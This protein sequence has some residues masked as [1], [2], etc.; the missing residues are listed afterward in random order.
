MPISL[1]RSIGL[2]FIA[3][4]AFYLSGYLV[5]M[6]A[7]RIL[8]PADY[9]K[10]SLVITLTL[11]IA[12]LIGSSI[13]IAM[14]KFLSENAQE[15]PG[16]IPIIK[17][18]G[19]V[20]QALCMGL[21]TIGFYVS[22]PAIAGLLG[23][24][25]LAPLLAISAFIIPLYA[26]DSFYFYYYSGTQRFA[27]QSFLKL[28]RSLLRI[29]VIL[30]LGYFLK[31]Q[32]I[33]AG[34]LLV[35]LAVFLIALAIDKKTATRRKEMLSVE[36]LAFPLR[37]FLALALPM[38][39]FLFLFET[40]LSFDIYLIKYLFEDNAQA[41]LYNAA[42]TVAR[43]P[44]YLFYALTLLLL[45][46][47]AASRA[48]GDREKTRALVARALRF[49]LVFAFP[50]FA[51]AF[52]YPHTITHLLFGEGFSAAAAFLPLLALALGFLSI[53]YVL[54]FAYHGAGLIRIPIMFM[55]GG[56]GLNMLFD[57]LFLSRYGIDAL[58][59]AKALA[60]GVLF[61]FFLISLSRSFGVRTRIISISKMSVAG[62]LLF[63]AAR[64]AGDT[65]VSLL[66]VAPILFA[67]Y[68]TLLS[69]LKEITPH[70]LGIVRSLFRKPRT[71]KE[72]TS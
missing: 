30:G 49:M 57:F 26:A 51:F 23:D 1:S 32:G 24:A 9:G 11:L 52:A 38:T 10:Y 61:G 70:D 53:I 29:T 64:W 62:T 40:L 19:A 46:L 43:I 65:P 39:L 13:P 60:A 5:Q 21:L 54:A 37:R 72:K 67:G 50:F 36:S 33:I 16:L 56:L 12:N 14:S 69:L 31:L 7:G 41:G 18:Q 66:F 63:L 4:F 48:E 58:P 59:F 27:I 42:L 3:E 2:L 34:Y 15:K 35:P 22:A 47:I 8:G 28:A 6:G 25:S 68:L 45:P 20:A 17:R 44:S 55:L 71:E